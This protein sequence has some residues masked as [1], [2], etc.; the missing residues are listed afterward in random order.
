MNIYRCIFLQ[1]QG[2]GQGY[3][4]SYDQGGYSQTASNGSSQ[5]YSQGS[6]YGQQGSY[7][8]LTHC[9]SH[10]NWWR[11]ML[12]IFRELGC[13]LVVASEGIVGAV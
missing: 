2:Y 5:G 6:G 3:G 11:Q 13:Q 4:Q 8:I 12:V 10:Y 9:K 1:Q 7:Y